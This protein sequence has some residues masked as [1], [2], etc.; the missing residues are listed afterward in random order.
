MDAA[1]FRPGPMRASTEDSYLNVRKFIKAI[2]ADF[3]GISR[4][5]LRL[6]KMQDCV[7]AS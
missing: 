5:G 1:I 3:Q 7:F 6:G 4:I 2:L